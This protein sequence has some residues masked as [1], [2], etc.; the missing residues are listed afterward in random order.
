MSWRAAERVTL[1]LSAA[2]FAAC[3]AIGFRR[4]ASPYL[5]GYASAGAV[6]AL[7]S[8]LARTFR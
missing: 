3:A 1:G 5:P 6:F 7:V 4:V 2:S 8:R